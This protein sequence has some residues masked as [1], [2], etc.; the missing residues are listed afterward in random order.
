MLKPV[1]LHG[2]E[3]LLNSRCDWNKTVEMLIIAVS[4]ME[5]TPKES[6]LYKKKHENKLHLHKNSPEIEND[7]TRKRAVLEFP[8]LNL[9][10]TSL[11]FICVTLI[12]SSH[13]IRANRG[14]CSEVLLCKEKTKR[15]SA[16]D[17]VLSSRAVQQTRA[18]GPCTACCEATNLQKHENAR[19]P[20]HKRLDSLHTALGCHTRGGKRKPEG[21]GTREPNLRKAHAPTALLESPQRQHWS[22]CYSV[23]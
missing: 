15:S 23:S 16:A 13:L 21:S 6:L 17:S 1:R 11:S 7:K 12:T 8:T 18:L 19:R 5:I 14:V 20:V 2:K 22:R 9:V 4:I 3:S 10:S